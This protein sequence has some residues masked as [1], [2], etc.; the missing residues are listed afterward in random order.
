MQAIALFG[1]P[2]SGT[3]WLGQLFNSSPNVA[4]RFQPLFSYAFKGRLTEHSTP[5]E[6]Q[7]FHNDLLDTDDDFVLQRR[8]ISGKDEGLR[9]KKEEITHL[10]WK[11]VR[12]HHIIENLLSTTDTKV[13]GIVRHPCA[14]INSWLNAPKEFDPQWD[15]LEE[16]RFAKK[17]NADKREEY[18]GYEKWKEV[19]FLYKMIG[20]RYPHR[21]RIVTY[22]QLNGRT[23][24]T[25][26]ELFDFCAIPRNEQTELFIKESKSRNDTD[27]YGVFKKQ[28]RIDD[29]KGS[30]LREIESEIL[31]D[32]GYEILSEYYRW[33]I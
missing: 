15:P 5:D 7:S 11:E 21:C 28:K 30:L 20:E 14:V 31:E 22:E 18:N 23:H 24:E 17:K 4:Y 8:N 26:Q 1:A 3:S 25:I 19:A 6:I 13:I 12:Y 16:W 32:E 27:P 2:R 9:F 33:N 10:V 29:W